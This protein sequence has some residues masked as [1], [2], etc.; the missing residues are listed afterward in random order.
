MAGINLVIHFKDGSRIDR[1]MT[2]V[3]RF[4]VERAVLTVISKNGTIGRYN[5]IDVSRVSIE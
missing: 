3:L 5:M 4:A 1:P 2:D